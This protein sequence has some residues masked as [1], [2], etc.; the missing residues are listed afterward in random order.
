MFQ[1]PRLATT[2]RLQQPPAGCVS[3]L[4]AEA[5]LVDAISTRRL[6]A[7]A[8]LRSVLLAVLALL[9]RSCCGAKATGKVLATYFWD[10]AERL[11]RSQ[12]VIATCE[13]CGLLMRPQQSFSVAHLKGLDK[14]GGDLKRD[15]ALPRLGLLAPSAAWL[16][17][18]AAGHPRLSR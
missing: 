1:D 7:F 15:R 6:V 12:H 4:A 9:K 16:S 2:Q 3:C 11:G 18:T 13:V 5:R 17:D 14:T 8:R 10:V